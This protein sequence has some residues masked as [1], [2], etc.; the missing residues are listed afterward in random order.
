MQIRR[1]GDDSTTAGQGG[2]ALV[3]CGGTRQIL[4][5]RAAD[6]VNRPGLDMAWVCST[7]I[8]A[9]RKCRPGLNTDPANSLHPQIQ[10]KYGPGLNKDQDSLFPYLFPVLIFGSQPRAAFPHLLLQLGAQF[11]QF[12][13]S[14]SAAGH[15]A[16]PPLYQR[17]CKWEQ[18]FPGCGSSRGAGEVPGSGWHAWS[19]CCSSASRVKSSQHQMF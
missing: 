17:C 3:P 6:G 19:S 12:S 5:T 10:P 11:S 9:G 1:G 18:G 13:Q 16:Q 4:W 15:P 2:A 14:S 8:L 7:G